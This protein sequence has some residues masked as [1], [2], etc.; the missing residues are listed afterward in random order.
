MNE[1]SRLLIL[2]GVVVVLAPFVAI[3]IGITSDY[4]AAHPNRP[5]EP[6]NARNIVL[7]FV[8][9]TVASLVFAR[10][11]HHSQAPTLAPVHADGATGVPFVPVPTP[12]VAAAPRAAPPG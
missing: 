9:V 8:V 12:L 5:Y 3:G 10:L 7:S 1:L 6:H 11:S 4:R 2:G